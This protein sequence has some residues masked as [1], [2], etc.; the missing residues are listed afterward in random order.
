MRPERDRPRKARLARRSS[1][2]TPELQCGPGGIAGE[3]NGACGWYPSVSGFNDAAV[4]R[5]LQT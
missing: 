3:R 2:F 1:R 5:A 4:A